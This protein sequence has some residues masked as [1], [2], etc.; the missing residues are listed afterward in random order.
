MNIPAVI[1][2]VLL[3]NFTNNVS[4]MQTIINN[5][6]TKVNSVNSCAELN[7]LKN[8]L[9]STVMAEF[10]AIQTKIEGY[11]NDQNAEITKSLNGLS[12][13]L[14]SPGN[15]GEV[16]SWIN[17]MINNIKAP[18]ENILALQAQ[19]LIQQALFIAQ[20]G[21]LASSISS[22]QSSISVK[23]STLKCGF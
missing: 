21:A 18:Y 3:T 11:F 6:Q 2:P 14:V 17:N 22:L 10:S 23:S 8:M 1:N 7:A 19:I 5:L 20:I 16:I 4:N 9:E 15:L 13:L 12:P